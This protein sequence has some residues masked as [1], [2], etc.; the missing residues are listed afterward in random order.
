[1]PTITATEPKLAIGAA[2]LVPGV[3]GALLANNLLVALLYEVSP[4][5][6]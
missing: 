2:G 4:T 6:A 5:D 1:V 3:L